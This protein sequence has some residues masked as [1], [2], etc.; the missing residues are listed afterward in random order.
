[1]VGNGTLYTAQIPID[2]HG[3]V[4]AGGIEAQ[5]RQILDNLRHTLCF[6]RPSSA[7]LPRSLSVFI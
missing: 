1:V 6:T 7:E 5:T 3:Q 2:A 4:V